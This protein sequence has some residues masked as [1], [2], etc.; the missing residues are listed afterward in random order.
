MNILY[1]EE[2]STRVRSYVSGIPPQ[3]MIDRS[4]ELEPEAV[5]DGLAVSL[6]IYPLAHLRGSNGLH[7]CSANS[8]FAQL[9]LSWSFVCFVPSKT[10]ID[11]GWSS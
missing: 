3:L 8:Y 9:E 4:G 6:Y 5:M 7:I 2:K 1:L 10:A 11:H